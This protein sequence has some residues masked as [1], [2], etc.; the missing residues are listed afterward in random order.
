MVMG[1]LLF[2]RFLDFTLTKWALK[3]LGVGGLKAVLS[4]F[5][6]KCNWWSETTKIAKYN[7]LIKYISINSYMLN[8]WIKFICKAEGATGNWGHASDICINIMC[9]NIV[10]SCE[11]GVAV[12]GNGEFTYWLKTFHSKSF[13][14]ISK[15]FVCS[16]LLFLDS[17][18]KT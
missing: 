18:M 15:H 1:H 2:N 13:I 16:L 12:I 17:I 5:I 4:Y 10:F 14:F 11:R 9:I 3:R 8:I 6:C 7:Q